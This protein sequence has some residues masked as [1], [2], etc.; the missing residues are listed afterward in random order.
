MS[1]V[2]HQFTDSNFDS[3]V[4]NYEKPVL[5]D[6]WAVWCGPCRLIEPEIEKLVKERGDDL[7]IGRLNVD[8]NRNTAMKYGISSIPTLLLFKSGDIAKVLVG[9]MPKDKILSELSQFL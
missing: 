2:V 6:F 9:A 8:E 5:V 7:K 3:E 4:I 1:E